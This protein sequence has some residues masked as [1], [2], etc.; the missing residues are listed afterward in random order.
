MTN[1]K[2]MYKKIYYYIIFHIK[3]KLILTIHKINISQN[4]N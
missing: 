4:A 2:Y 3:I 1:S